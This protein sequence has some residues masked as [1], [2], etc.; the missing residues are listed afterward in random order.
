MNETLESK[1][2]RWASDFCQLPNS[3]VKDRMNDPRQSV[4]R[5]W[6]AYSAGAFA[7]AQVQSERKVDAR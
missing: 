2:I 1:F 7:F 4:N 5:L 3:V 6:C